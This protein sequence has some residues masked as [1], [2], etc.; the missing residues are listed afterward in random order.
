MAQHELMASDGENLGMDTID[1]SIGKYS[2]SSLPL[3]LI[4][5]KMSNTEQS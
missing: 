4:E 5:P 1:I 2:G 3:Y